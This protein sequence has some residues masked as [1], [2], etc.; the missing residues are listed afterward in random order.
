[1]SSPEWRCGFRNFG[2]A[3][4]EAL[5]ELDSD[6]A[7]APPQLSEV[8]LGR[9][10]THIYHLKGSA[11]PKRMPRL[12]PGSAQGCPDKVGWAPALQ[13]PIPS[14][15]M[16]QEYL[17]QHAKHLLGSHVDGS[18]LM[19]QS[20]VYEQGWARLGRY[21]WLTECRAALTS[22]LCARKAETG[23]V[24]ATGWLE[25]GVQRG[26]VCRAHKAQGAGGAA[27]ARCVWRATRTAAASPSCPAATASTRSA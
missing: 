5:L 19:S 25:E 6:S 14:K 20:C 9:L 2:E 10:Q 4:Y 15:V 27:S 21:A 24:Q 1:M 18:K 23:S 7:V 17:W 26:L 11:A 12:L 22:P 16:R 13:L 8:E 3:D